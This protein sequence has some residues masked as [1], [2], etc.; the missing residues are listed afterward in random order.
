MFPEFSNESDIVERSNSSLVASTSSGID[1]RNE[2]G[3]FRLWDIKQEDSSIG[4]ESLEISI[5]V[6]NYVV[7]IHAN[8]RF[9]LSTQVWPWLENSTNIAFFSVRLGDAQRTHVRYSNITF[10]EGLVN[11]CT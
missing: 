5:I 11:A 9:A 3:R 2:A 1:T 8:D 10:Y 7:E 6:D 4:M